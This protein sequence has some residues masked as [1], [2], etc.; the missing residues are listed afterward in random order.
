VD[1][2]LGG[3]VSLHRCLEVFGANGLIPEYPIQALFRDARVMSVPDGTSDIQR[4]LIGR[5]LTGVSAF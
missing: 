4:L 5:N 2:G 3:M 1:G